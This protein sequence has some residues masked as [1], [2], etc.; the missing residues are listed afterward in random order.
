MLISVHLFQPR[1]HCM[2]HCRLCFIFVFQS[3]HDF[4][5]NG[6][7]YCQVLYHNGLSF[8]SLTPESCIGLLVEFQWPWNC[9]YTRWLYFRMNPANLGHVL[10]QKCNRDLVMIPVTDVSIGFNLTG[11]KSFYNTFTFVFIPVSNQDRISICA[12]SI[13]SSRAS[14]FRLWITTLLPLSS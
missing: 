3:G 2:K 5:V 4:L 10:L 1:F 7:L 9:M 6:I 13:R 11:I 12:A 14:S 8:L